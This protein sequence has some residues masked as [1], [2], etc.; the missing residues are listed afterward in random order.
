M[1]RRC[2]THFAASQRRS[3]NRSK[4]EHEAEGMLRCPQPAPRPAL[5]GT[6]R[7]VGSPT[8][9]IAAL[10]LGAGVCGW[11]PSS[12]L[13]LGPPSIL[14]LPT[15]ASPS[16]TL[17][18]STRVWAGSVRCGWVQAGLGHIAFSDQLRPVA[19][20]TQGRRS[21]GPYGSLHP[22]GCAWGGVLV[23]WLVHRR[24]HE[25][26][27]LA[28]RSCPNE[29][30]QQRSEFCGPPRQRPDTGC[31]V[32]KRRGR[33]Q[34]GRLSFES[35]SLAKQR[36][37]LRPPG[38][39]PASALSQAHETPKTIAAYAG[40]TSA[41]AQSDHKP[42]K[43]KLIRPSRLNPGQIDPSPHATLAQQTTRRQ[44]AKGQSLNAQ[45]LAAPN[46]SAA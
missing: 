22:S 42:S 12:Y 13:L 1:G 3:D 29:A 10:G 9:A 8:R 45:P 18:S 23:G 46:P 15:C 5:L 36:K 38:R 33:S 11:R 28:G 7:W 31:P 4:L 32:A 21:D 17:K 6:S 16:G 40:R 41:R 20:Q 39:D 2:G 30:A 19:P 35:F 37:G 24:M 44:R 27:A 43:R 34:Q 26:R 25:L 14:A